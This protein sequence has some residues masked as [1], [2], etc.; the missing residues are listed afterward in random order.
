MLSGRAGSEKVD[1]SGDSPIRDRAFSYPIFPTLCLTHLALAE[2]EQ[3]PPKLAPDERFKHDILLILAQ[4]DRQILTSAYL[5]RAIYDKN[6]RVAV[7]FGNRGDSGSNAVGNEQ[8]VA[9]ANIMEIEGRRAMAA[10]GVMRGGQ[11]QFL[12]QV[13]ATGHRGWGRSGRA[14]T[15]RPKGITP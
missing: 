15:P 10:R 1:L 14:G 7:V 5:A 13:R 12:P 11:S 6:R 8:A 3:A 2:V 4:F 9:L